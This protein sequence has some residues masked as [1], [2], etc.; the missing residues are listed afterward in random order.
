[1]ST[2]AAAEQEGVQDQSL[3]I[4]GFRDV[5]E[6]GSDDIGA[7]IDLKTARRMLEYGSNALK[8]AIRSRGGV[9]AAVAHA[10]ALQM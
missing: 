6:F 5:R 9:Q 1:M 7:P 3:S 4:T 2:I 10:K 8:R